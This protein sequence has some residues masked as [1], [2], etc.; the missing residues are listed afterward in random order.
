MFGA[1]RPGFCE[2]KSFNA[3]AK[4]LSEILE[5]KVLF[6]FSTQ[7]FPW[8]ILTGGPIEFSRTLCYESWYSCLM[9]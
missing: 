6:L 9:S 3:S 5:T 7:D 4:I 1:E 2:K 8:L